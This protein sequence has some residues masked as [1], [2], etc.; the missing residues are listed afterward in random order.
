MAVQGSYPF[1]RKKGVLASMALA[2]LVAL[3]QVN[4]PEA[5]LV[6]IIDASVFAV[7]ARRAAW[8][9]SMADPAQQSVYVLASVLAVAARLL[10]SGFT[11]VKVRAPR[12]ARHIRP[13]PACTGFTP[14]SCSRARRRP[15]PGRPARLPPLTPPPMPPLSV[16]IILDSGQDRAKNVAKRNGRRGWRDMELVFAI[17]FWIANFRTGGG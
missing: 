14:M 4:R 13:W 6:G 17:C 7:E 2:T 3:A 11:E 10:A 1:L 5:P 16:Q 9:G 12:P 8:S 15:P